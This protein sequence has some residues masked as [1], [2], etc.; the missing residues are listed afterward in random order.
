[1]QPPVRQFLLAVLAGVLWLVPA[2]R[3]HAAE[4]ELRVIQLKHHLAEDVVPMVRPL[5]APGESLNGL[6]SRL[7]VRAAPTTMMQIERLLAEI[8]RPR[9]N[10][11]ISL[12]HTGERERA[13]DSQE[14]TSDVRRGNTR[15]VVNN[16]GRD[17]SGLMV[18]RSAPN[19]T[20]QLHSERRV[21]STRDASTQNLT[22]LD[23]GRAFLRVGESIMLVQTF[24]A[25]VGNRPGIVTGIQYYD[26][27]TGFEVEPHLL[28]E[29]IQLTV[30]PRL[31]F[32]S[33]QGTQIIYFRDLR[34]V[35]TV[36]PGEWVDLGGA[37][38]STNEVNR[39]IL[40]TRRS[41]DSEDSR[42]LIRVDPQ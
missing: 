2:P 3:T 23:G 10:L 39:Q 36:K 41:T 35:V 1:M 29:Q 22:V 26:V 7:I 31:A 34:T 30:A 33:D 8:D 40:S 17:T 24:L 12:R 37:V 18:R 25:L 20:V 5:L 13:Q 42:F 38:E 9:R 4:T 21:T 11:R 14:I 16:S 15:I 32:R 6:D 27:T 19:G 28:G